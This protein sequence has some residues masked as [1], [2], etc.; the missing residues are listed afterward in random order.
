MRRF[1][2]KGEWLVPHP[3]NESDAPGRTITP[4]PTRMA[5]QGWFRNRHAESVQRREDHLTDEE[6]WAAR[7]WL[8]HVEAGRIGGGS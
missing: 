1:N 4:E 2:L 8:R 5:E 6:Q 7:E 3:P